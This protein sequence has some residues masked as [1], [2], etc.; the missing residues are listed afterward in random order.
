MELKEPRLL[1]EREL[2]ALLDALPPVE[3]VLADVP[4]RECAV[5]GA[6]I[7][8]KRLD[9]QYCGGACRQRAYRKSRTRPSSP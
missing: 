1:T 3:D 7:V 2:E 8:L 6:S 4:P 9:A 5:C